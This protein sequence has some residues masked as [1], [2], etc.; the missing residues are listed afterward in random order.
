M[1]ETFRTG[2]DEHALPVL[3][4]LVGMNPITACPVALDVRPGGL[5]PY[6]KTAK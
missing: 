4:L 5:L 1:R 6:R 2:A 3:I